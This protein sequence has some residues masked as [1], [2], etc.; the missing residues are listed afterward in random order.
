LDN[1][2]FANEEIYGAVVIFIDENGVNKG[3]ISKRFAISSAKEKGLDL[4]QV[5]KHNN[6][7]PICKFADIG[8]MKFEASKKIAS[9]PTETKE[10]MFHLNTGPND[11]KVKKN[12]IRGMLEKKCIVKFG[13]QL[14]GRERVFMNTAKD[15]LKQSVADF[16]D[17]AKWDEMKVMDNVVFVVLKPLRESANAER[18]EQSN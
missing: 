16:S 9:K 6:G 11:I 12:K 15:L 7:T 1:K 2:I 8:K 10:M 3:E 17:V 14:K 18:S 5:A 13:I 4:V